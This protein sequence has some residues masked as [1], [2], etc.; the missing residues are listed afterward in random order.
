MAEGTDSAGEPIMGL[1]GRKQQEDFLATM[2][3]AAAEGRQRV[4][5]KEAFDTV[6]AT[7]DSDHESNRYCINAVAAIVPLVIQR[8]GCDPRKLSKPDIFNGSLLAFTYADQLSRR[9]GASFELTAAASLVP[10]FGSQAMAVLPELTNALIDEFNRLVQADKVIPQVGQRF[11][12]WINE[13]VD[14]KFE[15]VVDHFRLFRRINPTPA[16][17]A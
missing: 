10:L 4:R 12:E 15:R 9:V 14:E 13:P 16:N 6:G 1:F 2:M 17:E 3:K 5:I 11:A 8:A 7:F